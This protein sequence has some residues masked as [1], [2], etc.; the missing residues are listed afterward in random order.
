MGRE[1]DGRG[2]GGTGGEGRGGEEGFLYSGELS[3]V[4][5]S[6]EGHFGLGLLSWAFFLSLSI[7]ICIFIYLSF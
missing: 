7:S 2:G 1:R 4:L 3:L 5:G 6:V